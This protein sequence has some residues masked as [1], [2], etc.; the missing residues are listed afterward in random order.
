MRKNFLV[1]VALSFGLAFSL[2]GTALAV[3]TDA[4]DTEPIEVGTTLPD[5]QVRN[6]EGEA[7]G[8]QALVAGKP[9]VLVFYRGGWCPYCTVQ[10]Q[11]LRD[12]QGSLADLGYQLVALSPDKPEKL[13]ESAETFELDYELVSDAEA[14]AAKALGIAFKVDADTI[15]LY[16]DYGIDLEKAS[17][18]AHHLL[19]VPTVILTDGEGKV[20]YV[21]SEADY[22]VRLGNEELLE[23]AK[24]AK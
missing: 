4:E 21:F 23:A 13:K 22:K 8:L 20:V 3:P 5:A 2:A 9:S 1:A 6:L 7:V 12:A 16:R 19:P 17:G 15:S 14:H 24:A 11:A 18:E 10:L